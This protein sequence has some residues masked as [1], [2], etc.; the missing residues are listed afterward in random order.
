MK[1]AEPRR[2]AVIDIG[3]TNAKV[4]VVDTAALTETAV[5]KIPNTVLRDGLYPHFDMEGSVGLCPRIP[6]G[7]CMRPNPSTPSRSPRMA[8]ARRLSAPMDRWRFPCSIMSM[9]VLTN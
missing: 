6:A 3:K 4:A 8:Q 1:M 9:T 2:V 5:R 7:D